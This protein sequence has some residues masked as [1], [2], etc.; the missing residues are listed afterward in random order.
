MEQDKTL[1]E[2]RRPGRPIDRRFGHSLAALGIAVAIV[3]AARP[4]AAEPVDLNEATLSQLLD[5]PGIGPKRAEAIVQFRQ[6][7][8][9]RRPADLMRVKGI[10]RKLYAR[11]KPLVQVRGWPPQDAHA[12]ADAR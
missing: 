10:G 3:V 6:E 1:I 4:A 2:D 7:R 11:I 8:P 5:L 9:F 12:E